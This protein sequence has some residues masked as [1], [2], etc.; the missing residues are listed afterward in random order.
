MGRKNK[1]LKRWVKIL[2]TI[3]SI[4]L[5]LIIVGIISFIM[6]LKPVTNNNKEI[7]FKIKNGSSKT[8]I[9]KN[10]KKNNLI[11]SE[12]ATLFYLFLNRD[13]VLMDGTY[14]LSP[15]MSTRDIMYNLSTGKNEENK[16]ITLTFVEGKRYTTYIKSICETF[17][18]NY[19]EVINKLNDENYLNSLIAKYSFLTTDILNNDIYYP[20]E[21]YLYPDTY[22]F[23]K[24]ATIEE[25]VEK[26]LDNFSKH[27]NELNYQNSQYNIHQLVTLASIVELEGND[28]KS[29]KDIAGVFYNRLN[30]NMNLG[31]DITTYYGSQKKLSDTLTAAEFNEI[32][33]YNTRAISK[34]GLPVGPVCNVSSSSL[35][36]VLNPN[37]S[38]YLYF[39]ADKNGN[40]YYAHTYEEHLQ[41][42]N[43]LR[44]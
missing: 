10:L 38:D 29:R 22:T 23:K 28:S 41:I 14:I 16:G 40:I 1:R 26:M 35:D 24:T 25:I 5:C 39:Y 2:I 8:D 20:L 34:K 18:F 15:S 19:D 44:K 27:L 7:I 6:L 21:G 31:S 30:N 13:M 43:S 33:A 12:Y 11:R 42:I 36:A 37:K 4:I 32:N 9:V 17:S 3:I